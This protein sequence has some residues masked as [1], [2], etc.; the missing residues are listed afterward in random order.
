MIFNP[1]PTYAGMMTRRQ[2]FWRRSGKRE[3]RPRRKK[4]ATRSKF[5]WRKQK[6]SQHGVDIGMNIYF[7]NPSI[8]SL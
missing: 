5:F 3:I 4:L 7:D 2:R 8:S 1:E 6:F